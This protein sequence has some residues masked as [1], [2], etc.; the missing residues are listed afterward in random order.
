VVKRWGSFGTSAATGKT[1]LADQL[2]ALRLEKQKTFEDALA[3]V[4]KKVTCSPTAVLTLSLNP[5][6]RPSGHDRLRS[7]LIGW[8]TLAIL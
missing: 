1:T 5:V 3:P 7:P 4:N 2:K 6:A 8:F